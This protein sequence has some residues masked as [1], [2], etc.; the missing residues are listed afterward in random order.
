MGD[1][2]ASL[3]KLNVRSDT[4]YFPVMAARWRIPSA[5]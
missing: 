2:I 5:S 1:Y 4:R 3:E